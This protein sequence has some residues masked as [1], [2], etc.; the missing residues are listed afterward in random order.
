M[1][2]DVLEKGILEKLPP[3]PY[4][5]DQVGAAMEWLKSEKE[6]TEYLKALRTALKV[7]DYTVLNSNV[8]FFKTHLIVAS[9][10]SG[11]P[12][13]TKN[14]KFKI[15]DSA[16]KSVEKTL[17]KIVVDPVAQEKR[18]CFKSLVLCMAPL[19]NENQDYL[20][21]M[22]LGILEDL[23]EITSGMQKANVTSP[24]TRE[25]YVIILGYSMVLSNLYS[26]KGLLQSTL[27]ILNDIQIILNNLNY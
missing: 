24:I 18:G 19:V 10:L 11:I 15:F 27:S 20:A 14:E 25:D 1:N 2:A 9:L 8:N 17:E 12:E 13:A 4:I 6:E 16:S 7:T 23:E 22:L 26:M 21:V 3:I 5:V